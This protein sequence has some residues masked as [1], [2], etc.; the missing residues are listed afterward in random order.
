[1]TDASILD[2]VV[3]LRAAGLTQAAIAGL[4]GIAQP[5]VSEVLAKAGR[6]G[7]LPDAD[8]AL[9]DASI[10]RY[11]DEGLTQAQIGARVGLGQPR[12]GAVLRRAD[13]ARRKAQEQR[14]RACVARHGASAEDILDAWWDGL[15][16]YD[17]HLL[18]GR[19][20]AAIRQIVRRA[21]RR[22]DPR[23][24]MRDSASR[25]AAARAP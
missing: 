21:R 10:L 20:E 22:G 3:R 1:M 14:A 13:A 15:G 25:A 11:R 19:S 6:A 23:A 8:R 18:S 5:R 24:V 2:Q 4:V 16:Q 7:R 17:L 12:V 9:R